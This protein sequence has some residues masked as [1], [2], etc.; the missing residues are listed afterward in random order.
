MT[1][2]TK[3][4]LDTMRYLLT[5]KPDG[6]FWPVAASHK[7]SSGVPDIIGVYHGRF[8]GIELKVLPDKQKP[9]QRWFMERILGADGIGIVVGS[10]ED[11]KIMLAREGMMGE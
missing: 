4:R 1:P 6:F 7:S 3:L 5:L 10:V 2:H 9:L 11:V 8:V